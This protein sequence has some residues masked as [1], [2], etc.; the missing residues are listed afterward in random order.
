[1]KTKLFLLIVFLAAFSSA[2]AQEDLTKTS[3]QLKKQSFSFT[4]EKKVYINKS[5]PFKSEEN[6][7][8]FKKQTNAYVRPDAKTRFKRYVNNTLGV[9]A[10]IGSTFSAGIGTAANEPEEWKGN[11]EGFGRRFASNMGRGAI[12]ET[13]VYG[14]DEA[15]K[16]DSHFYRS[17]KKDVGSRVKN[18]LLSTVTARKTNGK[19]TIGVSRLVG[20]YSASVIAAEAWYPKRFDYKDGLQSGTISLG[21][22]A[23]FNLFREFIWKK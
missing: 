9:G 1:M 20:T 17:E 21:I 3:L 5:N 11:F 16:L 18:A 4:P 19:R 13:A 10:L 12:R 8:E 14:L 15:L 7:S 6:S 23:A 2:N 22:N